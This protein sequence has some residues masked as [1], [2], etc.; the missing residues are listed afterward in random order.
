MDCKFETLL[1]AFTDT[2][3][4]ASIYIKADKDGVCEIRIERMDK[5][6]RSGKMGFDGTVDAVS[7]LVVDTEDTELEQ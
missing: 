1:K 5:D 6:G 2:P 7:G 4:I 3:D